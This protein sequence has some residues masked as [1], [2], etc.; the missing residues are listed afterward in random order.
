[1]TFEVGTVEMYP[2]RCIQATHTTYIDATRRAFGTHYTLSLW[3]WDEQQ[4]V[5][6]YTGTAI[7]PMSVG[8][9][10]Y[11]LPVDNPYVWY[12]DSDGQ[13]ALGEWSTN[14]VRRSHYFAWAQQNADGLQLEFVGTHENITTTG[15]VYYR[16]W[17]YLP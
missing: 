3:Y 10:A 14:P 6:R 13:V 7:G 15:Y 9:I 17:C 2:P 8:F 5:W 1:V 16:P 12:F 11:G 4:R